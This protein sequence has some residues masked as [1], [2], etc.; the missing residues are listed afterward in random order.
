MGPEIIEATIEDLASIQE[1]NQLLFVKEKREFDSTLNPDW[2]FGIDAEKYFKKRIE[3]ETGYVLLAYINNEIA[4]YLVGGISQ[5]GSY[6]L[7]PFFAQLESIFVLEQ[8]RGLSC[9]ANFARPLIP[10][11]NK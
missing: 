3:K 7:I 2:P 11:L 1:L 8:H 6:R 9:K 10:C 5:K 4:G